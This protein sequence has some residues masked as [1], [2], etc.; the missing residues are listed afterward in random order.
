MRYRDNKC[1]VCGSDDFFAMVKGQHT[2][3]YC[4]NCGRWLKWLPE[5]D[6][7]CFKK[8]GDIKLLSASVYGTIHVERED[9]L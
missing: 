2:G 4:H 9:K 7:E 6:V 1:K 8:A 5:K 3:C